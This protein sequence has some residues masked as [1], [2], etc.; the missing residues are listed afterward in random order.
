METIRDWTKC[1]DQCITK[2]TFP[3]G[4]ICISAPESMVKG[5]LKKK[6]RQKDPKNQN[7][8]KNAMKQQKC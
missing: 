1:N 6:K 3:T 7:M 4:Y 8:K 2:S 5:A